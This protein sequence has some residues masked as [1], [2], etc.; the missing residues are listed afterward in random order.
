MEYI[1]VDQYIQYLKEYHLHW[2]RY[3]KQRNQFYEPKCNDI[4]IFKNSK[5]AH[6]FHPKYS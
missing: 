4:N 2:E 6:L 5:K 3:Y 1:S